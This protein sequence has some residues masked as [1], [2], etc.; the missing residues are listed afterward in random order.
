ML[1]P[2]LFNASFFPLFQRISTQKKCLLKIFYVSLG[3]SLFPCTSAYRDETSY[4]WLFR[5][6]ANAGATLAGGGVVSLVF[7]NSLSF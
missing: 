6:P 2:I 5:D 3:I 1:L 4:I 7:E